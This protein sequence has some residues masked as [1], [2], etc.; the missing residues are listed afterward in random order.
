[1]PM[2]IVLLQILRNRQRRDNMNFKHQLNA[3]QRR[4]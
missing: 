3:Y 2:Y 4:L 1:M